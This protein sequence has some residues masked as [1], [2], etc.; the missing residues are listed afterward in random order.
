M[1]LNHVALTVADRERSAAFYAE[2]FGLDEHVHEDDHRLI[3]GPAG[4]GSLLALS[5]GVPAADGLPAH[6][7]FGFQVAGADDVRAAGTVPGGRRAG[8]GVAG[9]PRIRARPGLHPDGYRVEPF[10]FQARRR[11]PGVQGGGSPTDYLKQGIPAMATHTAA[12][13]GLAPGQN[14]RIAI[15]GQERA[16]AVVT[17]VTATWLGLRLVGVGAPSAKDLIGARGAVEY[18]D[19]DGIH[20]LRGEVTSGDGSSAGAIRFV[21]RSGSGPQFLGRRHHI[22]SSL[23]APVVLTDGRTAQK[24][25]GRSSNVSEGGMLVTD[26]VGTLPGVGSR[27]KFAIAP[28][29]CRDAIFGTAIVLRCDNHRGT[30]ALNFEHMPRAAADELARVVFENDQNSRGS[31]RR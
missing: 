21:P 27:L 16:T 19:D 6:N 9:Q 14:V 23:K 29:E 2:F 25:S 11:S 1:R 22:R 3:L 8:G 26:L 18:M 24:F 20:R 12:Q 28:R 17:H 31:R 5:E 4:G 15:P 30:L 10:A 13:P 7:Q